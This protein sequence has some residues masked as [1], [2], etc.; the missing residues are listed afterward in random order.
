V[1]LVPFIQL[2]AES[3]FVSLHLPLTAQS[4]HLMNRDT[5]GRMKPS[6]FL[7]NTARGGLVCELDLV[8]ALRTRR[9]AGAALDVFEE[10]PTL[11]DNPLLKLDNVVLTP[12]TAGSDLQS[13]DDMAYMAARS[14]VALFRG[15]W[16]GEQVVN[17]AVK[18]RFQWK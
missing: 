18:P 1:T 4:R 11:P 3:D 16:P 5:L 2:L 17:P 9:I 6:A 13:R 15:E 10:E 8:E 7:V 14:I 12:H